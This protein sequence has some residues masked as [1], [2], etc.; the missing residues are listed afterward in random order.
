MQG[1]NKLDE[2]TVAIFG[3]HVPEFRCPKLVPLQPP[4]RRAIIQRRQ[5]SFK[6]KAANTSRRPASSK[7]S[8]TFPQQHPSYLGDVTSAQKFSFPNQLH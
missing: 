3:D 2:T 8:G 5:G 6:L 4:Q 1:R 7:L